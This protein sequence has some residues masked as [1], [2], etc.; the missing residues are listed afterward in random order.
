MLL[1][2]VNTIQTEPFK[3][4][5]SNLVHIFLMTR[6]GQLL[7][8][9]SGSKVK[10]TYWTLLL[11][12]VNKIKHFYIANPLKFSRRAYFAT[13]ALL[14]LDLEVKPSRWWKRGLSVLRIRDMTLMSF[15]FRFWGK[16]FPLVEERGCQSWE[17]RDRCSQEG[18]KCI[19][20][21]LN[22]C[23]WHLNA[24]DKSLGVKTLKL[25]IWNTVT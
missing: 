20:D 17:N 24:N 6:G 16:T 9:R 21:G 1:N 18:S 19:D 11:S 22:R 12:L 14:L 4:G 7:I 25:L 15:I 3:L 8:L 10:V 5:P 23:N 13:L 2:L